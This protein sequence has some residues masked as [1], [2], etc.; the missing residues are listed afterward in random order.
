MRS[1]CFHRWLLVG[2]GGVC[3]MAAG[4][5]TLHEMPGA[6]KEGGLAAAVSQSSRE[7]RRPGQGK[8]VAEPEALPD[9]SPQE[10]VTDSPVDRAIAMVKSGRLAEVYAL[11]DTL[12]GGVKPEDWDHGLTLIFSVNFQNPEAGNLLWAR[13]ME[14]V[15]RLPVPGLCRRIEG[16]S[17]LVVAGMEDVRL[18]EGVQAGRRPLA[19]LVR[20]LVSRM[21]EEGIA[22][23]RRVVL[24]E[25]AP[26]PVKDLLMAAEFG[27]ATAGLMEFGYV[28]GLRDIPFYTRLTELDII[29][30]LRDDPDK[31]LY[32]TLNNTRH[33]TQDDPE[34]PAATSGDGFFYGPERRI[35]AVVA[36]EPSVARNLLLHSALRTKGL[37][38]EE[39]L[40]LLSVI[41]DE[42]NR[43]GDADA[44][45]KQ[46]AP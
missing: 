16:L 7:S 24:M 25:H 2:A 9:E 27:G 35:D 10:N 3:A 38:P 39:Q 31:L 46:E 40:R 23:E 41:G 4:W 1:F 32:Y 26:H 29:D 19:E 17:P 43:P 34:L 8:K 13:W 22:S 12:A 45:V 33:L 18:G 20:T 37:P 5:I 28:D 6:R 21:E 30:R 42:L 15:Q 11:V 44:T 14:G 36:A